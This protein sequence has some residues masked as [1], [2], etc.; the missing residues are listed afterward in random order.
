M[1][2]PASDADPVDGLAG[3][4]FGGDGHGLG[5]GIIARVALSDR[6][7]N[8]GSRLPSRLL[9]AGRVPFEAPLETRGK[10]GKKE[11]EGG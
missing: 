11:C 4:V 2:Q 10:Q 1:S 8:L 7:R 5:R 6:N 9:R 3:A